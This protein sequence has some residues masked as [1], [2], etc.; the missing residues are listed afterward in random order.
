V[1]KAAIILFIAMLLTLPVAYL[2]RWRVL[3]RYPCAYGRWEGRCS[4]VFERLTAGRPTQLRCVLVDRTESVYFDAGSLRLA[5]DLFDPPSAGNGDG[6]I[7]LHGSSTFGRRLPLIR[8]LGDR[9]R[10]R[11]Y[12]VLAPDLRGFGE[13]Q[14]PAEL[15]DAA[16]FD[17][18][19]DV[20]AAVE[21]MRNRSN[22]EIRRIHVIGHSFG[23]GA[24]LA[25]DA[26]RAGASMLVLI[27]P[28]RRVE[29]RFLAPG[30]PDS[31]YFVQRAQ[32]DM[33]L[34]RPPAYTAWAAAFGAMDIARH[35]PAFAGGDHVPLL[36]VDSDGED[37][38]DLAFMRGV[39]ARMSPAV[40]FWTLEGTDHYL[41][42]G[43][44]L[45]SACYNRG[46]V[47]P[48]VERLDEWLRQAALAEQPLP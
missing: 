8:I 18:A 23:A 34:P 35:V 21:Y 6:V 26:R 37:P 14:D 42:T 47:E 12:S 31:S 13:S 16:A 48:F 32:E 30:A 22:R 43:L 27:G 17:F 9:F 40:D 2:A 20:H 38:A 36:L 19:M 11:G 24:A 1:R 3:E 45:G 10:A 46:V 28:P 4:T 41:H 7:L 39:H 29:E 5:A 25:S 15:D 33:Q 44:M